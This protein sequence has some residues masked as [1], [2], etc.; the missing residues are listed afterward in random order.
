VARSNGRRLAQV[1]ALAALLILTVVL[2]GCGSDD[3]SDS[4]GDS[5]DSGFGPQVVTQEDIDGQEEGSPG[6]GLLEWWQA[7]QFQDAPVVISLTSQN[8]L[9]DVGE[10]N[11]EDLVKTRGQ[12]LQGVEVLGTSETGD[13]ASV[14]AGLLT[15][16]P[17]EEG[18]EIPDEP[19]ASRPITFTMEKDGD[20]WLFDTPTYL[21]PLIE[22]MKRAEQE[23]EQQSSGDEEGSSDQGGSG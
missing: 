16:Q 18:G 20:Q 13:S 2:L 14:R 3:D 23:A 11:L 6:A 1:V 15:F 7:F 12:G 5:D 8:T 4:N 22:G 17:E 9:D 21:E 10:N 19:T